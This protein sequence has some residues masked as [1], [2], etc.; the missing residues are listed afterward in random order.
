ME[1][2]G[3]QGLVQSVWISLSVQI[4]ELLLSLA[5]FPEENCLPNGINK[6]DTY[7]QKRTRTTQPT[8]KIYALF[9]LLLITCP[10]FNTLTL[11]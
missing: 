4:T 7:L 11:N 10:N 9:T 1:Q 2:V 6:C 8:I 3:S 5:I